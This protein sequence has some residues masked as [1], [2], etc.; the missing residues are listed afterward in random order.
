MHIEDQVF[1]KRCGHLDGKTLVSTEIMMNK[2]NIAAEASAKCSRG[3]F[4]ICA[5][6]DANG[7]SGLEE[8]IRRSKKYIDA[9]ASMIF[10]EGLKNLEEFRIV[11]NELKNYGSKEG[12]FLLANMTEFGKTNFIK[13]GD[14]KKLGYNCV[15]YPV[16]TLRIAMRAV[17]KFLKDFNETGT[18]EGYLKNMQTREELYGLLNY[19]PGKEWSYPNPHCKDIEFNQEKDKK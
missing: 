9:G 4:I 5:R 10:P 16:T 19:E 12:P 17:D 8:T 13:L 3:S 6:T 2:I 1:P 14:F 18:Q 11:A 15:I 7:V